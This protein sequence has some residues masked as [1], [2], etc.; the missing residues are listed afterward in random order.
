[1]AINGSGRPPNMATCERSS[2]AG[3]DGSAAFP[4]CCV[5]ELVEAQVARTPA[6]IAVE[7]E[8][9]ELTYLELNRRADDLARRLVRLGVGPE[10][11][12]GFCQH[13]SL[14]AP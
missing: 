3:G 10:V 7:F 11:I 2:L 13:R 4:D 6:A 12:V 14:A 8:G 1:M 9:H 5:H